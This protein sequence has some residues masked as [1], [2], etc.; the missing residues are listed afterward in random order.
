MMPAQ[1]GQRL[2]VSLPRAQSERAGLPMEGHSCSGTICEL[3]DV[4]RA[5]VAVAL[6]LL[7]L[8]GLVRRHVLLVHQAGYLAKH[9]GGVAVE[10]SDARETLA[11]LEGVDDERLL[12]LEDDLGHL[13]G[14]E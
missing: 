2:P 7:L 14:L 9:D 5:L 8:V 4:G 1:G 6:L 3:P 10:E 12:G 13:V 11:V